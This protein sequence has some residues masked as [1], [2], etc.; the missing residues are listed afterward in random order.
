MDIPAETPNTNI[1]TLGDAR[2]PSPV[3]KRVHGTNGFGF[4]SEA[5]RVL[6]DV[7]VNRACK[8][9]ADG[10]LPP[11]YELAGPR[12]RI[13]FDPSKLKCALV[14]CGGL[15]PGLNDIIRSIVLELH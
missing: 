2:I 8:T 5:D 1:T 11:S 6:I 10:T 12:E 13:Y 14:T 7:T 15:C 9:L 3:H 4:V